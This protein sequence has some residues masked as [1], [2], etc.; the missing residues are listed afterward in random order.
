MRASMPWRFHDGVTNASRSHRDRPF[1]RNS[2]TTGRF[3]SVRGP[4]GPPATGLEFT[5]ESSLPS[6]RSSSPSASR[7]DSALIPDPHRPTTPA[8]S[9]YRLFAQSNFFTV[10]VLRI[11]SRESVLKD[12]MILLK[13]GEVLRTFPVK[14]DVFHAGG[15]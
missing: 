2:C 5:D 1:L 8:W 11:V 15:K 9:P 10:D 14:V 12:G 3:V 7:Q 6:D 4:D 13:L